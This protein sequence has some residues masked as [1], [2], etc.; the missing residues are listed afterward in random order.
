MTTSDSEAKHVC[1]EQT[2][3]EASIMC[4]GKNMSYVT[5]EVRKITHREFKSS[6]SIKC[7]RSDESTVSECVYYFMLEFKYAC[8]SELNGSQYLWFH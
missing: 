2:K 5:P 1:S 7:V 8:V 6:C 3:E 4:L